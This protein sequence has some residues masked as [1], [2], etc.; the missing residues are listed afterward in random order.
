MTEQQPELV[1]LPVAQVEDVSPA[2]D[3]A[4]LVG[5]PVDDDLDGTEADQ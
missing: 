1:D 4:D 2:S 3:P 5:D